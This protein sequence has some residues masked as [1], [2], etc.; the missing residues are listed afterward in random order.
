MAGGVGA[1][2]VWIASNFVGKPLRQFV[3]LKAEIIRHV[4]VFSNVGARYREVGTKREAILR[5][6]DDGVVGRPAGA[7]DDSRLD[8]AQ[9]T[10]RD[11]AGRM[12]GFADSDTI[13]TALLGRM[14]Y[15][16][17]AAA[18]G[19]LQL[20]NTIQVYGQSR[21]DAFEAVETSLKFKR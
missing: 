8:L 13:A 10:F 4:V 17:S 21:K 7:P 18:R 2:V 20:S 6:N 11:L 12:R 19:L 3:D 5:L 15:D 9:I 14:G 16:V 1:L